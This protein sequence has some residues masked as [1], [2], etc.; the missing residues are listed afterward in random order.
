M[1]K[2]TEVIQDSLDSFINNN[3]PS[4]IDVTTTHMTKEKGGMC[5]LNIDVQIDGYVVISIF[6]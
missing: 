2:N 3:N 1:G 5:I 6:L 4:V